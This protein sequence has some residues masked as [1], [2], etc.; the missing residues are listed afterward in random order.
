LDLLLKQPDQAHPAQSAATELESLVRSE[1][2][3][4]VDTERRGSK[5]YES[6]HN[7]NEVIGTQYGDRVLY[8]LIQNAHDAHSVGDGGKISIRL[9]IQSGTE[10][11]LYIANGGTGFRRQDIDAVRNLAISA[12]ESA[13]GSV[14]KALDSAASRRLRMMFRF[15][16][17]R[18]RG[19]Q[20][21]L[22]ATASDLR[23][24]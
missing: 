18:K 6:L 13:R 17:R 15:F 19:N 10:G 22:M 9:V 16:R 12:K 7:L 1:L 2:E 3:N 24:H 11:M 14:I 21:G 8:E 5:V 20:H 4:A 23:Q